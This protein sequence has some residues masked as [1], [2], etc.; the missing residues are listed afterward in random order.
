MERAQ[1]AG[2]TMDQV[3]NSVKQVTTIMHE[4]STASREQSIGVDQVNQAVNHMDQVTQQN[5]G[6]VEE[7][8]AAAISLADEAGHLRD[9]FS[10]FKFERTRHA[11]LTA[12]NSARGAQQTRQAPK[13]LAA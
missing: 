3:V 4:I 6:L 9:A 13:C 11:R 8:A 5:A 12:V 10:L 1:R 7:A 2:A